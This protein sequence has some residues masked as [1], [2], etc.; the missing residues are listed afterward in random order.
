MA[1]EGAPDRSGLKL[2]AVQTAALAKD[3][4]EWNLG[5]RNPLGGKFA[6]LSVTMEAVPDETGWSTL[7]P[8]FGR[9][10]ANGPK[11]TK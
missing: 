2:D 4:H 8:L 3:L 6:L 10:V 11:D 7:Q 9:N 1:G 5:H